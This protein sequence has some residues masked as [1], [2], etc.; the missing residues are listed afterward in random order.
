MT[1]IVGISLL[2]YDALWGVAGLLFPAGFIYQDCV[3]ILEKKKRQKAAV[4]FKE[5]LESVSAGLYAGLSL[6]NSYIRAVKA[7]MELYGGKLLLM[8]P[9]K[10][11]VCKLELHVPIVQ[12]ISELAE[13]TQLED[14]KRFAA[15]TAV[16]QRNGG[17]LIHIISQATGHIS[18]KMKT[19]QEIV[20]MLAAKRMEQNVMC[21][22]PF[23]MMLY[24]KVTNH[25]Y[26]DVLYHNV[27]GM[28]FMTACLLVI[29]FAYMLGRHI[30]DICV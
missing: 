11:G 30:V 24:M 16:A 14:I 12:I 15:L 9:L 29:F 19:D 2:F 7:V 18:D 4:E 28:V 26:F 6:E 10:E 25:A 23:V 5:L 27:F 22:M 17:N 20:S 3:K 1:G 21:L 13:V 8:Q